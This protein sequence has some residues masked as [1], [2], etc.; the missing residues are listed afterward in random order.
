MPSK[1]PVA[2][3]VALRQTRDVVILMRLMVQ[4]KMVLVQPSHCNR[5]VSERKS[6]GLCRNNP[7]DERLGTRGGGLGLCA[8]AATRRLEVFR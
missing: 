6:E 5:A 8:L 7:S 3:A 2:S 4:L 1:I